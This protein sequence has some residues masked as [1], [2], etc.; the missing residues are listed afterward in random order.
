MSLQHSRE[1]KRIAILLVIA[2]MIMGLSSA[3]ACDEFYNYLLSLNGHSHEISYISSGTSHDYIKEEERS[4]QRQHTQVSVRRSG[5]TGTYLL[6]LTK[7]E[8]IAAACSVLLN[9]FALLLILSAVLIAAVFCYHIL[10]IHLKDG[11]K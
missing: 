5:N 7:G 4:G 1:F 6:R 9:N 2:G 3:P 10:F 11:C 8:S